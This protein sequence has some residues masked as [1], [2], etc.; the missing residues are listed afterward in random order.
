[1][2]EE[3]RPVAETTGVGIQL[4]AGSSASLCMQ[5]NSVPL[6]RRVI[7]QN[8]G[9]TTLQDV[10]VRISGEPAYAHPIMHTVGVLG[11]RETRV[12][13][14]VDLHLSPEFLVAHTESSRGL[15]HVSVECGG[16]QLASHAQAIEVLAYDHWS[17]SRAPAE[18]LASFVMP[19]H[20]VIEN[21]L[22][23]TSMLLRESGLPDALDGYQ[24]ES[25]NAV[26]QMVAGIYEV[27]RR[28]QLG[29]VSPPVSIEES[30]QKIRTPERILQSRLGTCLDLSL[31]LAACIEQAGLHPLIVILKGHAFVAVWLD[32]RTLA[33][34]S[35]DD[36]IDVRKRIDAGEMLAIESTTLTGGQ[37]QPFEKAVAQGRKHLDDAS[38]FHCV[39]DVARARRAMIRPI[40]GR[41]TEGG[42]FEPIARAVT[43]M[44]QRS[45]LSAMQSVREAPRAPTPAEEA[46]ARN[47]TRIDRW[48]R[49]LLDLTMHNRLLSFRAGAKT[50]PI[51]CPDLGRFEDRLADGVSFHL[52]CRP[53]E[54]S[55]SDVRDQEVY[56]R[57]TGDDGLKAVLGEELAT[58]RVRVDLDQ[59]QLDRRALE[60][61][62]DARLAQEES[63]TSALY[64]ALG[65]LTWYQAEGSDKPRRAPLLLLPVNIVR[66]GIDQ[67]FK[68]EAGDDEPRVNVTLLEMLRE[69]FDLSVLGLDPLPT[70]EHGI[71]VPR[72][73]EIFRT[74]IAGLKRWEVIEEVQVGFF[75]FSKF[76]MWRDLEEHA[77]DLLENNVVKHLVQHRNEAFDAGGPIPRAEALDR[78]R[79]ARSTFCPVS[80]DSSQ[81]A[82]VFAAADGRSFVLEGPPGTGKSQ[83]ITNIIA[84]CMAIGKSVLF[85]AEKNVALSVVHA[86]LEASGL[87]DY[88]LELHSNKAKKTDVMRQ[89]ERAMAR[90]GAAEPE[91]WPRVSERVE[92]LR[93]SLNDYVEALHRRRP[94]GET[95]YRGLSYLIGHTNVPLVRIELGSPREMDEARVEKLRELAQRVR[96]VGGA[97]GDPKVHPWRFVAQ[98]GWDPLWQ[99]RVA[100]LLT[101]MIDDLKRVLASLEPVVRI[102]GVAPS[103]RSYAQLAP[104]AE[105]CN[106]LV[107]A[108]FVPPGMLLEPDW[109][110][111]QQRVSSVVEVGRRRDEAR[112]RARQIFTA[113]VMQADLSALLAELKRA[114]N[115]W[116]PVRWLRRFLARRALRPMLLPGAA[117]PLADLE[118]SVERAVLLRREQ[119]E[120][121]SLG[122]PVETSL[123]AFYQR[124]EGRWDEIERALSW[125]QSARRTAASLSVDEPGASGTLRQRWAAMVS[126]TPEMLEQEGQYGRAMVAFTRALS[127][128]D[129]NAAA[130]EAEVGIVRGSL[131]TGFAAGS[132][133]EL[134]DGLAALLATIPK[135]RAW[136]QWKEVRDGAATAGLLPIVE[137]FENGA[138][139]AS[140]VPTVFDK[141]YYQWFTE[142]TLHEEPA[143]RDF[144]AGE[145]NRRVAEF[146]EADDAQQ[147]LSR[148]AIRARLSKAAPS[149]SGVV[150]KESALGILR[151]ETQKKKR[152]MP[153]RALLG[154]TGDVVMRLTPCFLMSPIS[155]AQY[156]DPRM[157]KFDLVIFDE[158]S[159]IP[160]WEA[161]GAI[162]RGRAAIIVGDPKQLPPT[163][164]F[165]RAES[166]DEGDDSQLEDLESILDDCIGAGLPWLRLRW[167]YRSRHESLIAFSNHHYYENN[168]LTL[169]SADTAAATDRGVSFRY[170]G[171]VYDKGKSRTNRQEAEAVVAEVVRRLS[172][173]GSN[174]SI[175]VVTLNT[176]QRTLI[177][178][179][180]DVARRQNPSLEPHF[181][182]SNSD[183]VF[184]KNLENVQGDERD[185]ILFSIGY[186][187][188]AAGKVSMNFGPMNREGGQRR[189][190]VAITR[191]RMEVVVFS[192]LR[193]EQIDLT[194]T[195]ARGVHQLRAF[196]DYAERGLRS[197][198]EEVSVEHGRDFDSPFEEMVCT[199]LRK[200]G[201]EVVPQV[202]CSGYRIDLGVIDPGARGRFLMGV[203][204]DGAAYHSAASARDRDKLRASVLR[205][206]GWQLF[207]IWSTDFWHDPAGEIARL[208]EA[209]QKEAEAA[210]QRR[211]SPEVHI[212]PPARVAAPLAQSVPVPVRANPIQAV[213]TATRDVAAPLASE[214]V[215]KTYS[216]VSLGLLGTPDIFYDANTSPSIAEAVRR[217]I[218]Q[219]GPISLTLL[220]RRIGDAWCFGRV[221]AQ[222]QERVKASIGHE[223]TREPD[224]EQVF[225]WPPQTSPASYEDFRAN[226]ASVQRDA[227]D[228]GLAEVRNAAR[229]LLRQAGGMPREELTKE[230]ARAFGFQRSG[231]RVAERMR[232]GLKRLIQ[233]GGAEE[234]GGRVVAVR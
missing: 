151:R 74:A 122:G 5:Q 123:G 71:D 14:R 185:V 89:I 1:M 35:D 23:K 60:I 25:R 97:L 101:A 28:E 215:G 136:C 231:S 209:L 198:K 223:V 170:V 150:S 222:V 157:P 125:V 3:V 183:G 219:E 81:L 45:P 178:D 83:T 175:G 55:V 168:L 143:L 99:G 20:P 174:S 184:I 177:E 201:W 17:G 59:A 145:H 52:C 109:S 7:L 30:G 131:L 62:R 77:Q 94:S 233:E 16:A 166:S 221:T 230:M 53:P 95:A 57:I 234:R 126:E 152:H 225:L 48:K 76:L 111:L 58:K 229:H 164:F 106:V 78:E 124:G 56:R 119:G 129:A 161:I 146:A 156:L 43:S 139:P 189:L 110:S 149:P 46:S 13:D 202:G 194:R 132:L 206:L 100:Q 176:E 15:L 180:L 181:A 69:D 42:G 2:M 47:E 224:G 19:N 196:L 134:A 70:D 72:V 85:V 27:L 44:E 108:P 140:L 61:F 41:V 211:A 169:P 104:L 128:L 98:S 29:Y 103:A 11:P 179:L 142:H 216:A 40:S 37:S 197:L 199:R 51:L 80:A 220:S 165:G 200:L 171:G 137:A 34:A 32:D 73:F 204:C 22:G 203:E 191:A 167:H 160:A 84:Q 147:L 162:A 227:G 12:L 117:I 54:F 10:T 24:R 207:R 154:E 135:L 87:G 208:H 130:L 114:A 232:E 31:L 4:V 228:I 155:V 193:A 133:S 192:S 195:Q 188:D 138:I 159:Q 90:A 68:L 172:R 66:A 105:A 144:H 33:T 173:P 153:V 63:G 113:A 118:S 6:I 21:L 210:S 213:A 88:C 226:N 82:A 36:P 141:A 212:A 26:Q 186:G 214:R 102:L 217:T 96:T 18:L 115:A 75:S 116:A 127:A 190:N 79:A 205:G 39:V 9:P 38:R 112:A 107:D 92:V 93:G 91:Q 8:H 218:A 163:S 67:G 50:L 86:R 120:L 148:D 182:N 158:A 65:F 49:K 121:D 187:A 64:C